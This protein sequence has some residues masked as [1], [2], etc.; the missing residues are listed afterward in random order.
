MLHGEIILYDEYE[1]IC[2][3]TWLILRALG[4]PKKACQI[5]K[6][7]KSL[8]KYEIWGFHGGENLEYGFL[9]YNAV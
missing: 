6:N 1:R 9:D 4:E 8:S 3:Q 2:E 7:R 5:R